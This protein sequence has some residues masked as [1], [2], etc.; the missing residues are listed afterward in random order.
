MTSKNKLDALLRDFTLFQNISAPEEIDNTEFVEHFVGKEDRNIKPSSKK[1]KV[2]N[3]IDKNTVKADGILENEKLVHKEVEQLRDFNL[4]EIT[5]EIVEINTDHVGLFLGKKD[6]N[7]QALSKKFKVRMQ[8]DENTVRITG[9]RDDVQMARKEV[10]LMYPQTEDKYSESFEV[11]SQYVGFIIG[12]EGSRIK[13]LRI[14]HMVI[15]K[16]GPQIQGDTV[17]QIYGDEDNVKSA[18][19]K[20]EKIVSELSFKMNAEYEEVMKFCPDQIGHIIGKHG[21][22]IEALRQEFDVFVVIDGRR[23][24]IS[25]IRQNV[26]A[27]RHHIQMRLRLGHVL[28][29]ILKD[30]Q[31]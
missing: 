26:I 14:G 22:N 17:V 4:L 28:T 16:I 7:I 2:R 13:S 30:E 12:R 11:K 19:R 9:M 23:V 3:R 29:R 21:K 15:I 31:R 6:R 20:I 24:Q 27:A 5:C 1:T 18:R 8:V 10:E 25:G